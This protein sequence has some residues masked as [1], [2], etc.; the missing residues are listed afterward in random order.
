V[1]CLVLLEIFSQARPTILRKL[2]SKSIHCQGGVAGS[3]KK[4]R[5]NEDRREGVIDYDIFLA[6][7]MTRA[8]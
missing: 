4:W 7:H 1:A 3:K 5:S 8:T 2:L 6:S